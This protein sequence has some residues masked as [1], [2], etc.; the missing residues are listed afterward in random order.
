MSRAE[1]NN[2]YNKKQANDVVQAAYLESTLKK[3][4][5]RINIE[6]DKFTLKLEEQRKVYTAEKSSLQAELRILEAVLKTLRDERKALMIPIDSLKADAEEMTRELNKRLVDLD[7]KQNEVE[8]T[9]LH[10]NRKLDEV[11]EKERRNNEW[12]L[13]LKVRQLGIDA[14]SEQ[15]SERHIQLNKQTKDFMFNI[16]TETI[17][18]DKKQKVLEIE[19]QKAQEYFDTRDAELKNGEKSL[20]DRRAAFQREYDNFKTKM[21]NSK[22]NK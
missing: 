22:L 15:V 16:E 2:D 9:L 18:L 4:Q 7:D 11:T 1:V 20:A 19:R 10:L 5:E 13:S 8:D 21:L 6:N 14:E 17:E 3:L 12:E